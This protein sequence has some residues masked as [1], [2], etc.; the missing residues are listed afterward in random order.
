VSAANIEELSGDHRASQAWVELKPIDRV[1][2]ET[3]LQAIGSKV[4]DE[5]SNAMDSSSEEILKAEWQS[6]IGYRRGLS[7]AE[8]RDRKDLPDDLTGIALSGG[9][10]RSA[11]FALG[12]LQALAEHDLL[13]R[14][15]YMS[16]VSGGG[17]VGASLTWLTSRTVKQAYKALLPD[18][19]FGLGPSGDGM[20]MP[21]PYGSD[22]PGEA[23]QPEQ[24][25]A[26]G[27]ML[28]Y[29]RQ[30]GKY[31]TP[32]TGITLTSV[33]VVLLRGIILN[34]LVWI[35]LF[36]GFMWLLIAA[37]LHWLPAS[38]AEFV[39]PISPQMRSGDEVSPALLAFG[40]LLAIAAVLFGLCV[41]AYVFYSL[42]T[43]SQHG[44]DGPWLG[45]ARSKKY[46]WRRFFERW[47]RVPF[48]FIGLLL[49]VASVPFAVGELHG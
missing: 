15:D 20:K 9:G 28:R 12:V 44:S 21:F 2:P 48:W 45:W 39:S 6:Y 30:H 10:I 27:K 41:A 36:A 38:P 26:P 16:T 46:A 32:G 40:I 47:M 24:A 35:P 49:L 23:R 33:I 5:S 19:G 13:R 25:N 31:L 3:L 11:T 18:G 7:A 1:S 4:T 37:S 42:I 14:F 22:D 43:Y 34:L 8:V 17:Y 29:L